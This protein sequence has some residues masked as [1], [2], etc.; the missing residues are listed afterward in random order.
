MSLFMK[1]YLATLFSFL[2]VDAAWIGLVVRPYY[3]RAI[4]DLLRDS[5][6]A[7]AAGLFY[8]LYIAGVVFLAVMPALSAGTVRTALVNGAIIGALAYGTYTVTN[9]AIL[10]GWTMGLVISD[11]LWGAFL[12][13]LAAAC[14]YWVAGRW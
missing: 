5:F 6:N 14:G 2:L 13:S 11:L 10:K 4:G 9:F 7:P 12:T 1:A 3:Q 8:L